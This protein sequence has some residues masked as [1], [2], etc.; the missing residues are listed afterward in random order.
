MAQQ[1]GKITITP[2]KKRKIRNPEIKRLRQHKKPSKKKDMEKAYKEGN[3]QGESLKKYLEYQQKLRE[4][5]EQEGRNIEKI[6]LEIISRGGT[7]SQHF[8][9]IRK[10]I[11]KQNSCDY[12]L[13]T[14]NGIK[15]IDPSE[16]KEH[17][18][19]YYEELYTARE[20]NPQ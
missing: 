20:G 13:M 16:H 1:L 4:K 19:K 18:A 5:I 15:V 6:A 14:E 7:N 10:S 9:K 8:W 17:I 11:T 2:G 12:D 3:R